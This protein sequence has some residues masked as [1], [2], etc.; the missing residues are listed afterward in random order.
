MSESKKPTQASVL[1][2]MIRDRYRP[3]TGDDG[4]PYA[5][6]LEGPSIAL[7]L[8]GGGGLRQVLAR[9]FAEEH[10]GSV[11]GGAALTDALN[12]FAGHAL[13][14]DPEPIH[15]RVAGHGSA[16]VLDLGTADGRCVVL[17]GGAWS[18]QATSPVLFRRTK[19]IGPLPDPIP[20][21]DLSGLRAL[22][23]V[24]DVDWPLIVG[25]MV[26]AL[27]PDLPYPILGLRGLRGTAKSNTTRMV[28]RMVS[29]SPVPTRSTPRDVKSWIIGA[30]AGWISGIDNVSFVSDE[31]SDWLC[32]A[33]TGEGMVDRALY[34]DSDVSII[35][36][37]RPIILNGIEFAGGQGD[38]AN[39]MLPL[40]LLP[41]THHRSEHDLWA[42]YRRAHPTALG[43]LLDLTARVQAVRHT[44]PEPGNA[45]MA[46][47]ARV[48]VALDHIT[49]WKSLDR[50]LHL[51][52]QTEAES[53]S[54]FG[55]ALRDFAQRAYCGR[56]QGTPADL[57][58]ALTPKDANG[59]PRPPKGWPV[60]RRMREQVKRDL[61]ALRSYGIEVDLDQ[62]AT[63]RN[64]TRLVILTD[65]EFVHGR[66]SSSASSAPSGMP[67]DLRKRV[68]DADESSVRALS[69]SSAGAGR[70]DDADEGVDGAAPSVVRSQSPSDQHGYPRADGAD[71]ADGEI[72][73]LTEN[74]AL[75]AY[76]S[77]G[78]RSHG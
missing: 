30:Y 14:C 73:G 12:A 42:D 71:D 68:D 69:A 29:P 10:D 1:L 77:T 72:R 47:F 24:S 23:N 50:Y 41:I 44:L 3:L 18:I 46:D 8:S 45:R 63:D 34:T 40:E 76:N 22:V 20:G 62:R 25:W 70:A 66:I 27:L 59:D 31:F 15:L 57:W 67:S 60:L 64:R 5:V 49:G 21:G 17:D 78:D 28:T 7:P 51:S 2:A 33:S 32:R 54:A 43:A 37:R 56:W 53:L 74:K 13:T 55:E 26:G 38:L 58:G 6:K 48:L 35:S 36:F 75:A 61:P 9:A 16:V 52:S 65:S 39:R 19:L 11:P 4:N